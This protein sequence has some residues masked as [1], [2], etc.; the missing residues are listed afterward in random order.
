MLIEGLHA[1]VQKDPDFFSKMDHAISMNKG[2]ASTV[3]RTLVSDPARGFA[4]MDRNM[5]MANGMTMFQ[6]F[7]KPGGMDNLFARFKEILGSIM[8]MVTGLFRGSSRFAL[9]NPNSRV[10]RE[11]LV[12]VNSSAVLEDVKTGE[13]LPA[14]AADA[15][16][17][18]EE[19]ARQRYLRE[20][21]QRR[22][23]AAPGGRQGGP[24]M[25][26]QGA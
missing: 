7:F 9:D 4:E 5:Q 22:Q 8:E 6:S 15:D 23:A 1:R 10:A 14:T 2:A 20:E 17:R 11:A 3:I 21:E 25:D 16:R 19:D 24:G 12:A 26:L 18:M 13:S